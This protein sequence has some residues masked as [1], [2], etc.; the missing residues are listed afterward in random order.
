MYIY[1]F[2]GMYIGFTLFQ[3]AGF[4]VL[5]KQGKTGMGSGTGT[6]SYCLERLNHPRVIVSTPKASTPN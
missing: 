1:K 6:F 2:I 4:K 3:P 5:R